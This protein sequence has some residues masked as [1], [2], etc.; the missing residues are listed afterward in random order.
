LTKRT[1][2]TAF[3][4]E[5]GFK[6]KVLRKSGSKASWSSTR[7]G[8]TKF[9]NYCK[10]EDKPLQQMID[11]L[12]ADND[13]VYSTLNSFAGWLSD[14][15]ELMPGSVKSTLTVLRRYLKFMRVKIDN[16]TF[17]DTVTLPVISPME[18][19]PNRMENDLDEDRRS[20][21]YM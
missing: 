6:S 14:T 21:I 9:Q 7:T 5:A 15:E 12:K 18:E 11:G 20:F 8:I 10:Q 1:L 13:A 4:G 17:K 2:R 16:E 3:P 19:Q